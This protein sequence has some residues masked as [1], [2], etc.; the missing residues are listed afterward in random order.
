MTEKKERKKIEGMLIVA[1]CGALRIIGSWDSP[2]TMTSALPVVP[3]ELDSVGVVTVQRGTVQG[4][5]EGTVR[6]AKLV[7]IHA[8]DFATRPMNSIR[9]EV[10]DFLH[11]EHDIDEEGRKD[12]RENYENFLNR[13][14]SMVEH[15]RSSTDGLP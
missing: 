5:L 12:M 2:P 4:A 15:H 1:Q 13:A 3:F 7:Q 11:S 10:C 9:I 8:L 14:P 6:A